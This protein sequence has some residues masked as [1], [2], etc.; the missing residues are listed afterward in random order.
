M[1]RKVTDVCCEVTSKVTNQGYE[2]DISYSS[3]S[4]SVKE[5]LN[6]TKNM[7]ENVGYRL[8]RR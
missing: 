3:A 7:G 1:T 6:D 8:H 5:E 4:R 2:K